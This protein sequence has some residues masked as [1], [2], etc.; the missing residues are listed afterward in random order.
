VWGK[1]FF[2]KSRGLFLCGLLYI[3]F[4][5]KQAHFP[6]I[7]PFFSGFAGTETIRQVFPDSL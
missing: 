3:V 6:V 7:P 2:E 1:W 5:K 4:A